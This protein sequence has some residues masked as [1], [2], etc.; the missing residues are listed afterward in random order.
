MDTWA[1]KRGVARR[2]LGLSSLTMLI[3]VIAML[4]RPLALLI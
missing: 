4:P 1:R 2:R 3:T